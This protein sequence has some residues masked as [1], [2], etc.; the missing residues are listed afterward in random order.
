MLG[1][2]W[3]SGLLTHFT[4]LASIG[5]LTIY[6]LA[7]SINLKRGRIYIDCGCGF[8]PSDKDQALSSSLVSRNILLIGL[9]TLSFVPAT[10]RDLQIPDYVVVFATVL[11]AGLLYAGAGQ[12]ITNRSAIVVWRG[13]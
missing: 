12:L 10:E 11:I 7:M 13:K 1:L 8:G 4:A 9:V 3:M 5:L 6:A 2:C